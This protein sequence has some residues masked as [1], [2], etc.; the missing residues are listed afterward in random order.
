MNLNDIRRVLGLPP[1]PTESDSP[2]DDD[3]GK[4]RPRRKSMENM[5]LLKVI[6]FIKLIAL[7]FFV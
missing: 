7:F 2:E 5:D 3:G 1:G 6:L 4:P